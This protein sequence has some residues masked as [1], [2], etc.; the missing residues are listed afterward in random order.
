MYKV[1]GTLGLFINDPVDV[2]RKEK[3]LLISFPFVPVRF[4]GILSFFVR[5]DLS[6]INGLL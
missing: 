2:R 3:K 1:L 4:L 5:E 6:V